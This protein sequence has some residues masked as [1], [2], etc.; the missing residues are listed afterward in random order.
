MRV[1]TRFPICQIFVFGMA[2]LLCGCGKSSTPSPT[3]N[4][5]SD[6][7]GN[8]ESSAD[9]ALSFEP[10]QRRDHSPGRH[11]FQRLGKE[12]TGIDLV[13]RFPPEAPI[14]LMTDQYSGAGVAIGDVD[15]DELP[16]VYVTN[17]D[18]GNRLYR[19]LG[20]FRF[21]DVTASAD[22]AGG[23]RWCA[24]AAM[25]DVDNDTDLDLFVSV[26]NAPN[27]L[28]INQGNG[29]FVDEAQL[30]GL[31]F[32][33]ASVMMTF[34]DYDRDGDLDAYLVTHRM[35][36]GGEQRLPRSTDEALQRG[37]IEKTNQGVRVTDRFRPWFQ[38]MS[39]EAGRIE[40]VIAG[41]QDHLYL[42]DGDGRFRVV[43]RRAGIDGYGIGLAASWWDYNSDGL[44]DLYVSNDY[45]G[46]DQLYHN[47]G[48][49]TFVN[50]T[51]QALPHVPWFSMGS[52]TADVN[53][54]GHI[55]LLASDMSGTN[56]FKQKMGMGDMQKDLWFLRTSNPQQYMRN[57]LY[58]GTGT[59]RT[60]EIAQMAGVANS[61]W[62]WSPLFG[63]LDN[64]GWV[65]LFVSNGMS[66]DF[67]DSDLIRKVESKQS[68]K[69]RDLPVR[70]EANLVFRN[71]GGLRFEDV[72]AAWQ[73]NEVTA[74][75]G[76]A[77]ADLD[78][79]GD[80]DL[81]VVNFDDELHIYRNAGS[82]HHGLLLRLLGT[83]SN[84]WGLGARVELETDAGK[85]TRWLSSCQGFMSAGEP[86]IHFG[87]GQH[88][89]VRQ[90]TIHWPSGIVQQQADLAANRLYRITETATAPSRDVTTVEDDDPNWFQRARPAISTRHR[91]V[92]FDDF[93]AQPL[94]P[95]KLSQQGPG[96]A[97][98]DVDG[99]GLE[100]VFVSGAAGQP[101]QFL[102]RRTLAPR[103]S[104]VFEDAARSE[105]L[106]SL[107]FDC[108]GDGDRDLYVV[109]GSV[110][111]QMNDAALQDHLY[112]NDGRG[113][114]E[115][116][117][118]RLPTFRE[119][120]S[121]VNAADW[122]RDGD[123]DLFVGGRVVP[124]Q[125]PKSTPSRFLRNDGGDF[126]LDET[127]LLSG[128]A[129]VT[130]VSGALWSDMDGDGWIDL[131]V[132]QQWGPVR[133]FRNESGTLKETSDAA[134]MGRYMGWWNGISSGDI[135]NDGDMDYVVTNQGLNSKYHASQE[136]P[137]LLFHGDFE[138]R[139]T[140]RIVEA[141]FEDNVLYPARGRSCSVAAMPSLARRFTSFS[142]FASATLGE[143]YSPERLDQAF[144]LE[145]NTLESGVFVNDGTGNF[146]FSALP[147]LAQVSPGYGVV[148]V[149]ANGD[150]HLDIYMVHNSF[151]PQP[152]TGRMDGGM[153][154]L[155]Q[156]NGDGYF[157]PV[158]PR[159]SGLIVPGD[160][161]SLAV[162]DWNDDGR[163]DFV[164]GT[165]N[166]V[167]KVFENRT[168]TRGGFLKVRLRG[169]RW[170]PD[171]IGARVELILADK[172]RRVAEV[173]AGGGYLSQSTATLTFG[174][175]GQAVDSATV[176]W[177]NGDMTRTD[178]PDGQTRGSVI[179]DQGALD[180]RR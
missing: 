42:N 89:R 105:Q 164:I 40:L 31:D 88:D 169:Q 73:L 1:F 48:D 116:A 20:G 85:Q 162:T 157:E 53:N 15:G 95:A 22:V 102:N 152:E 138:G 24:G 128:T 12:K 90:L 136:Y 80:L 4:A 76:A 56:H 49:G 99:D 113:H 66:R 109:S 144:R 171:A 134:G 103:P 81:V 78:R 21:E 43:N 44:P 104:D 131:L 91:E 165:N 122:D 58:L 145:A 135:D 25:A 155:M 143:V 77:F 16:D 149:D 170:N 64:D 173:C 158:W 86:L 115:I 153:S 125:Y 72:G 3:S 45:K 178:F 17:Y 9:Y 39:R 46:A 87:L 5:T 23:G 156:G 179:I 13:H 30:R 70:K 75:Y 120:G 18:R 63:D 65:D 60:L 37:I 71:R 57:A 51:R 92:E 151:S 172:T 50:M 11:E 142:Q 159:Q 68:T 161:K 100:D 47:Q 8:G 132:A 163:P 124:G 28:Y 97:V 36:I 83:D 38:L 26:F 41:Q 101:G 55:D 29:V 7:S 74:S 67:M 180:S 106:G 154:L 137:Q 33:G 98:G 52:A 147:R 96:L 54:D 150:S 121:C 175:G 130:R 34:C 176:T 35:N 123:L 167:I 114:F 174:T 148:V 14:E 6:S 129:P 79:D 61:D 140:L 117:T 84:R 19:N 2:F 127:V 141:G 111:H 93:A 59:T 110:E 160:A 166:D 107:L 32:A 82:R 10:L 112:L 133:C 62:T 27:L 168:G 118:E 146:Q 177:P 126:Q 139:G 69:W 108:D 94:L 119:S